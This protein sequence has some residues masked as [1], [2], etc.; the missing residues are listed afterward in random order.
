MGNA[1]AYRKESNKLRGLSMTGRFIS[2]SFWGCE[3]TWGSR[4]TAPLS[5]ATPVLGLLRIIGMD[6]FY[7][8]KTFSTSSP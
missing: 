4:A 6:A 2:S 1:L 8:S 3:P 5:W 7:I